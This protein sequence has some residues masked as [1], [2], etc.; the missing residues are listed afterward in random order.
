MRKKK[1]HI[2]PVLLCAAVLLCAC[3]APWSTY[4]MDEILPPA[5]DA[6]TWMPNVESVTVTRVSDGAAAVV[7]GTD[8]EILYSGFSN[9]EC[10]RRS[11]SVVAM[12]RMSIRLTDLSAAPVEVVLGDYR[13]TLCCTVGEYRYRPVTVL[14]D[15]SYIENLFG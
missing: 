12:Y 2:L 15:I 13:G 5:L 4:R 10:T 7:E 9:A 14:F 1:V 6:R 11:G 8:V 3:S